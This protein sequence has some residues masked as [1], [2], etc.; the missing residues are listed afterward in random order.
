MLVSAILTFVAPVLPPTENPCE[1][2]DIPRLTA[3]F[4]FVGIRYYLHRQH[5]LNLRVS[6]NDRSNIYSTDRDRDV[7][8]GVLNILDAE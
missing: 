2:V 7:L 8:R 3:L 6:T 1:P 4:H 5:A